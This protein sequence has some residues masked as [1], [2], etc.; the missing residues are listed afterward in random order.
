MIG[1]LA[2]IATVATFVFTVSSMLSVGMS[3]TVREL[4]APLRNVRIVLLILAINFVLIPLWA[5]V[6]IRGFSPPPA[7]GLGLFLIATGA[8]APFVIKLVSAAKGHIAKTASMLV[9]LVV[10]TVVYLP[11]VI[12]WVLTHPAL[13]GIAHSPVDAAAIARPL[14]LGVLLPLAVGLWIRTKTRA[15]AQRMQ[16]LMGKLASIAIIV[17]I[18]AT[19]LANLR[20][21]LDLFTTTT[22]PA[23]AVFIVGAF[24]IGYAFG[25][26]NS[27]R[28]VVL[29][30]GSAQR[31]I[32]AAMVVATQSIGDAGT[33]IVVVSASVI[34][35]ALLFG[36]AALLRRHQRARPRRPSLQHWGEQWG[37]PVTE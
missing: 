14:L 29:G 30:L 12:P 6:V 37:T 33:I 20:G 17:L 35:L 26:R 32:A 28:R 4:F 16:P 27:E 18:T 1:A 5:I 25:G 3:F 2:W 19:V 8:G 31:N 10:A 21:I 13:T 36:L 9:L 22:A 7:H 15:F 23:I 11:L 24:A 34:G